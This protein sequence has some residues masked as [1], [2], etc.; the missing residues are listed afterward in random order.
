MHELRNGHWVS[1]ARGPPEVIVDAWGVG[2]A[3]T[4]RAVQAWLLNCLRNG[5]AASVVCHSLRQ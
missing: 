1:V 2:E 5:K 4:R 3:R